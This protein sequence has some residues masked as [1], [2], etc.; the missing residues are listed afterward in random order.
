MTTLKYRWFSNTNPDDL[1]I[2]FMYS[3][4]TISI[5]EMKIITIT[6]EIKTYKAYWKT[7]VFT[8]TPSLNIV[9]IS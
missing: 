3:K 5:N 9:R 8:F 7:I 1:R 4:E 6:K 2:W